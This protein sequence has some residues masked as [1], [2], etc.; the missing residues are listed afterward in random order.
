MRRITRTLGTDR[1]EEFD[2]GLGLG[3]ADEQVLRV[4][5]GLRDR[6]LDFGDPGRLGGKLVEA[7]PDVDRPGI[8]DG[9]DDG[10]LVFR[11]GLLVFREGMIATPMLL[12]MMLSLSRLISPASLALILRAFAMLTFI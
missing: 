9:L 6:D 7:R 5:I 12:E 10:L 2:A 1:I 11:D 4:G 8:G 3:E